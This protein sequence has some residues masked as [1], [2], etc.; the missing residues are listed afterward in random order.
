[1]GK[2]HTTK[3]L[4]GNRMCEEEM[5]VKNFI[6]PAR[7]A[8]LLYELG[9]PKKR[10]GAVWRFAHDAEK[11]LRKENVL[12]IIRPKEFPT[13]FLKGAVCLVAPYN[14][15]GRLIDKREAIRFVNCEEGPFILIS[16]E[17]RAAVKSEDGQI[18]LMIK[19]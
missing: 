13:D 11:L 19:N 18:F 1:M 5:F 6:I 16:E 17:S 4:G 15:S 8:R 2:T 14:S 12:S 9:N 3:I 10:N 7:Q